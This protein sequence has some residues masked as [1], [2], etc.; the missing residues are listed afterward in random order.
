MSIISSEG[1]TALIGIAIDLGIALVRRIFDAITKN[2]DQSWKELDEI[3]PDQ[4]KVKL[5][6][7]RGEEKARQAIAD[8]LGKKPV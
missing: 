2:D 3:F 5:A 1:K 7:L 4:F 8:A 6:L